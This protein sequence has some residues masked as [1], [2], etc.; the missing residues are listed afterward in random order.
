MTDVVGD[1]GN[2]QAAVGSSKPIA[3]V[4]VRSSVQRVSVL[5]IDICETLIFSVTVAFGNPKA[6]DSEST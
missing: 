3:F 2:P 4:R 1:T 5:K 6:T